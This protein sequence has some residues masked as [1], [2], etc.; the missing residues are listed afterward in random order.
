MAY[1]ARSLNLVGGD[2]DT[3]YTNYLRANLDEYY[4]ITNYSIIAPGTVLIESTT[5]MDIDAGTAFSLNSAAG[6]IN[7]GNDAVAQNINIGTAGARLITTGSATAGLSANVIY[8][9]TGHVQNRVIE[10]GGG[11]D[12]VTAAQILQGYSYHGIAGGGAA[13]LTMPDAADINTLLIARGIT[14]AAGDS[15]PVMYVTVTDANDLTVTA[16][17]GGTVTGTAAI[18]ATETTI[19]PIYT[20]AAAITFYVMQ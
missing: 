2:P 12:S 14:P 9:S 16:G 6:V 7:I 5:T 18:N 20:A 17:A 4:G 8:S 11:A 13:T 1:D 10:V 3:A 19:L 15:L